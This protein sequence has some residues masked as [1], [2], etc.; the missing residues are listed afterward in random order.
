[1]LFKRIPAPFP[2]CGYS[3]NTQPRV[4]LKTV[5]PGLIS[6]SLPGGARQTRAG[7]LARG[8]A[9]LAYPAK[10]FPH[11]NRTPKGVRGMS[12]LLDAYWATF[13]IFLWDRPSYPGRLRKNHVRIRF[14]G[15]IRH[16]VAA[17]R[18]QISRDAELAWISTNRGLKPATTCL[19]SG[20]W[21]T[22]TSKAFPRKF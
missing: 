6:R 19:G 16:V 21:H 13:R 8:Y 12:A 5:H 18:V 1:V 3:A 10:M 20:N 9:F 11:E 14:F 15:R 7:M 22:Y 17:A 2:G 4:S